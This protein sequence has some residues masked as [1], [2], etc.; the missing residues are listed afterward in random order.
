MVNCK[1]CELIHSH[2]PEYSI[3]E[4]T[5]NL[6]SNYPRCDWHWRYRCSICGE[7]F[8]F[9]G[10]TWCPEKEQFICYRCAESRVFDN[11]PFWGW[12]YAYELGCKLCGGKHPAL[13]KL[14]YLGE[15]PWQS[16]SDW[17]RERIG[18]SDKQDYKNHFCIELVRPEDDEATTDKDINEMWSRVAEDLDSR[19]NEYGDVNRQYIIDPHLFDLLG[20]VENKV[21]LD[22]GCGA[23][24]LCRLLAK[25]GARMIG[26]DLSSKFIEIAGKRE[27]QDPLGIEYYNG[28]LSDLSIFPGDTFEVII[29]NI[30]LIDVR[31]YKGALAELCRVLKP[32]GRMIFSILHPCFASPS[33]CGWLR[34]PEDST[35]VEDKLYRIID[36]YFDTGRFI[37]YNWFSSPISSYHRTLSDYINTL[38]EAGFEIRKVVEPQPKLEGFENIPEFDSEKRIPIF[39][40]FEVRKN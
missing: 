12:D 35:R 29:S 40:I 5:R 36:R 26:V 25:R 8:H 11:K 15:H 17:E 14:E 13:D 39:L 23:G 32:G 24:Y 31:D 18:L 7:E 27:R 10:I 33:V 21:I 1:Y 34:V 3:R 2:D 20:D 6:D 4:A 16:N 9:N 37:I 30:V 28:S 38:I 19:Y 22:A